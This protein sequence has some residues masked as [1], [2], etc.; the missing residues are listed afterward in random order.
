MSFLFM[1]FPILLW[2]IAI[3]LALF[4]DSKYMDLLVPFLISFGFYLVLENKIDDEGKPP[5]D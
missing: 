4:V 1:I 3:P 2:L 5:G